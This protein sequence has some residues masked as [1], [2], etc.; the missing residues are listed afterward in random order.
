MTLDM[1]SILN[2]VDVVLFVVVW[3][4]VFSVTGLVVLELS[5]KSKLVLNSEICP[6]LPPEC[7]LGLKV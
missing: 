6:L 3:R 4:H 1:V 5:L 7:W 2:S